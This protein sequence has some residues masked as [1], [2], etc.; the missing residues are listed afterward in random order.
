MNIHDEVYV[1]NLHTETYILNI[2]DEI[3]IMNIHNRLHVEFRFFGSWSD[4]FG[5]YWTGIRC[6]FSAPWMS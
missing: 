5:K 3:Y 6:D 4:N 2:Q 1:M